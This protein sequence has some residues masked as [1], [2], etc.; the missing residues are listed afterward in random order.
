MRSNGL[1]ARAY[2]PV[3]DL[4]PTL[5]EA[6]LD[7]LRL[8]GI[9][10]YSKP[11]D[12]ATT[13]GFDRPD[14]RTDLC[15]RLYVDAAAA[16]LAR[17]VIAARD[18]S[19][20]EAN[21]DLAWAQIVAGYD[22][23]GDSSGVAPWPVFED[24]D[25][26]SEGDA[27]STYDDG[28]DA[29]GREIG[30]GGRHGD[31]R[32]WP[33]GF[34]DLDLEDVSWR[35]HDRARPEVDESQERYIPPPPPPLPRLRPVDQLAWLGVLGG[36]IVLLLAAVFTLPI[37]TWVELAAALGFVAGFVTLVVGLD[38]RSHDEL[39]GDDGAQV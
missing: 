18:P 11:A 35:R 3:A 16:D 33:D 37:P 31:P 38:N 12:R 22:V 30:F 36:P 27:R 29:T 25:P 2:T 5:S 14:F 9:A 19:L 21:D 8:R 10:A 26:K 20:V 7:D 32:S 1:T 24:I 23:P 17:E 15:D 39:D 34:G 13:A 4:N 28:N 6:L